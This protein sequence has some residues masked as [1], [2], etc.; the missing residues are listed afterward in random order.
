MKM[1]EHRVVD[2]VMFKVWGLTPL[3]G[4]EADRARGHMYW[5]V[6]RPLEIQVMNQVVNPVRNSVFEEINR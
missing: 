1:V 2:Q 6:R 5:K 3:G 4:Q